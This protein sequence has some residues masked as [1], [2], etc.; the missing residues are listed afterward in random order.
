MDWILLEQQNFQ[1]SVGYPMV[2]PGTPSLS[3][4]YK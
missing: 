2:C 4:I 1:L 3:H